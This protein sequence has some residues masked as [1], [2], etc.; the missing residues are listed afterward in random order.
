MNAF[1]RRTMKSGFTHIWTAFALFISI[2]PG[3]SLADI[4]WPEAVGRLAGERTNAETCAAVLKAYG[5]KQ[6]I[7]RDQLAYGELAYGEA[8]ANFDGVIAGLVSALTE[9]EAPQS[10]PVSKPNWNTVQ[11]V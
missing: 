2:A 10:L 9:G 11:R 1:E 8:K 4:G 6:Q 3:I 7:S 5:D